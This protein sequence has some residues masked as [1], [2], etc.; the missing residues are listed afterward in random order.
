MYKVRCV[1]Y[2]RSCT[3]LS[4]IFESLRSQSRDI[5]PI[6]KFVVAVWD[7]EYDTDFQFQQAR[8]KNLFFWSDLI[9]RS[10]NTNL[11]SPHACER[12]H[13]S[14]SN[15][16][17]QI[18]SKDSRLLWMNSTNSVILS[19]MLNARV[20]VRLSTVSLLKLLICHLVCCASLT[21]RCP[22]YYLLRRRYLVYTRK[23]RQRD[24]SHP[25]SFLSQ[26]QSHCDNGSIQGKHHSLF[27]GSFLFLGAK[28]W[29]RLRI[30]FI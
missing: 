29:F 1:R 11:P 24:K 28:L 4:R 19:E 25:Q 21:T 18:E 22:I 23:I 3:C 26:H 15:T 17:D 8:L 13:F 10:G 5:D 7:R 30:I 9:R 27:C 6:L 12:Y 16:P 20:Y 2:P 14:S